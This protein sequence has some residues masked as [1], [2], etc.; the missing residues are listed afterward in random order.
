MTI[1]F[2]F[3]QSTLQEEISENDTQI[4]T[5]DPS[6]TNKNGTTVQPQVEQPTYPLGW[7]KYENKEYGYSFAYPD[8]M[9]VNGYDYNTF[10]QET[11][12]S[13]YFV[14]KGIDAIG[15]IEVKKMSL[16]EAKQALTQYEGN[17][18]V[19]RRMTLEEETT[20]NGYSAVKYIYEATTETGDS[21]GTV[22][23][24]IENNGITYDLLWDNSMDI[25]TNFDG[26]GNQVLSTFRLD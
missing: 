21:L 11:N 13:S 4:V 19:P 7:A 5:A 2:V 3:K 23:Y 16:A 20:F 18:A 25:E 9:K 12:D 1:I 14:I 26:L 22:H 15:G 24:L 8:G 17:L 6:L 10:V